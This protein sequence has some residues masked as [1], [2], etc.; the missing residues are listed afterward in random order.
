MASAAVED[1]AVEFGNG[2]STWS[3]GRHDE[4]GGEAWNCPDSPAA[5]AGTLTLLQVR[6]A[7]QHDIS[8]D[9]SGPQISQK[10]KMAYDRIR[11]I[12]IFWIS[13]RV[14]RKWAWSNWHSNHGF[15]SFVFAAL[16]ILWLPTEWLLHREIWFSSWHMNA[17]WFRRTYF[18]QPCSFLR[19]LRSL[20]SCIDLVEYRLFHAYFLWYRCS[21]VV[22]FC[23]RNR[24]CSSFSLMY[25]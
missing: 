12:P 13:T 22:V 16:H 2:H 24:I 1:K 23:G 18:K 7:Y 17:I 8:K 11:A 15:L 25:L 3:L 10:E 21:D 14:R 19:G 9:R 20:R 4:V 5:T 6:V